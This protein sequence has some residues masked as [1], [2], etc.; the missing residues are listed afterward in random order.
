MD[1]NQDCNGSES[2]LITY[3]YWN[4]HGCTVCVRY[5]GQDLL[6]KTKD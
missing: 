2:D 5:L 1:L 6:I 4:M 3:L